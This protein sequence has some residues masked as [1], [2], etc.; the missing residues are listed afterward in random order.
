M[1]DFDLLSYRN[2]VWYFQRFLDSM[3]SYFGRLRWVAVLDRAVRNGTWPVGGRACPGR[4]VA[5]ARPGD[6]L[7][8]ARGELVRRQGMASQAGARVGV[9]QHISRVRC[10]ARA[11][12]G[13]LKSRGLVDNHCGR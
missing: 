7:L 10:G 3:R 4:S 5:A 1:A 8:R 13:E 2:Q 9:L 11:F 6:S 12:L